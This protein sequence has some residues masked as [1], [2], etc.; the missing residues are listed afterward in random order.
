MTTHGTYVQRSAS[1]RTYSKLPN[2]SPKPEISGYKSM[3][4]FSQ[5]IEQETFT[6]TSTLG[7][8]L[9]GD[10]RLTEI[11]LGQNY[12]ES[13]YFDLLKDFDAVNSIYGYDLLPEG[14]ELTSTKEEMIN[15]IDGSA[16]YSYFLD[17]EGNTLFKNNQDFKNFIKEHTEIYIENNWNNTNRT[18]LTWKIN[19][20]DT[21]FVYLHGP[22]SGLTRFSMLYNYSVSYDAYM[23]Y[24]STWTNYVYYEAYFNSN[25][26]LANY[27]SSSTTSDSGKYDSDTFDINQNNNIAEVLSYGKASKTINSIVSSHQDVTTYV[28]T[29]QSNYS[30]GIVDT[31]NNS[32]YEYKLRARTGAADVT[33]FIIYTN[34]EEAQPEKTRWKGEF[35]DVNFSYAESKGYIVKPYYSENPTAGNLYN[36]DGTLNS[37]WKKYIPDTPAII[38]NGL[39][40]TFDENFKTYNSSDY[41]YIYYYYNGQLYRTHSYY[42]TTLAGKTIEIPSTNIYFIGLLIAQVMMHMDLRLII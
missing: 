4:N 7:I 23:E 3:T 42:N 31:S 29:D 25:N 18:R 36:E 12:L 39:A 8:Y 34:I 26:K 22:T 2:L 21:P 37:N 32:E 19:F 9:Y 5:N 30:T 27:S 41:L 6:G 14:M 38:A 17:L 16:P 33:N 28:K 24:G 1:S 40:I 15:S 11:Y 35:L 10:D 20:K 13:I